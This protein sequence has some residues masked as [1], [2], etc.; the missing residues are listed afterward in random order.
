MISFNFF[1][2]GHWQVGLSVCLEGLQLRGWGAQ[3]GIWRKNDGSLDEVLQFPNVS[4]PGVS[5]QCIHRLRRD[6]LDPLVHSPGVKFGEMP[7]QFRNVFTTLPQ[8]RNTDRKY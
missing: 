7:N 4:R 8:C 5:H 6:F 1:E 3:Y 2:T